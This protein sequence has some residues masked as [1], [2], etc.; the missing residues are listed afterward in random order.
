MNIP[1]SADLPDK[2]ARSFSVIFHPILMPVYGMA[3]IFSAPT[4][5]SY[6]PYTVKKFMILIILVNNVMVPLSLMPFFI[7]SKLIS[8]WSV[9]ERK[10]RTILLVISTILYIV[11]TFIFFRFQIPFFLKS[12]IL[13]IA[14]LSLLVTA[15]NFRWKISIH[16]VASGALIALVLILSFKMHNP[17]LWYLVP[18]IIASGLVLSSRLQLNMHSPKQ[19]WSGFLT[20]FAG[21]SCFIML[22]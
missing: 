15:L 6:I 7:H 13:A 5:Y 9:R 11:T 17:L 1:R 16:S 22:F 3:V 10:D 18:S 19:V 20:G 4:L 2:L 8:S 12:Y 21:L 14:F